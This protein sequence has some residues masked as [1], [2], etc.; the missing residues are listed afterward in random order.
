[1]KSLEA[2]GAGVRRSGQWILRDASVQISPGAVVAV[3]GAN[4]SGKST[5][6]RCM[7][8]LWPATQGRVM[9]GEED[10]R[11]LA[12][13]EI[14]RA[15]T[16]VPQEPHFAFEFS[17]REI[18]RM[19]RYAHRDR[20]AYETRE[21]LR[22]VEEALHRADIAHLADRPVV[23]L[24]GGEKQRVLIARS[25]ATRSRILLLDEPTAN[26]DIDHSLDILEL[27]RSVANEGHAIAI[28][29]HDLNAAYRI[30]DHVVL[31]NNGSVLFSGK[32]QDVLTA[33]HLKR[34]FHVTSETLIA[35]DGTPQLLFRR[36]GE[37]DTANREGDQNFITQVAAPRSD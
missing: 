15:I 29:T 9:L 18:V 7:G 17:V 11:N 1:M 37:S 8:G 31:L 22:I 14:A 12:R 20:F 23:Q 6:L 10:L 30:A 28:A 25:L 27:C 21:D 3:V 5:L 24:S 2:I 32:P 26:L 36:L 19:G 13:K 34:A 35:S 4:G 16:Y 33:E